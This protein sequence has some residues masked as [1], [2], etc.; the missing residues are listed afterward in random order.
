[1]RVQAL[2]AFEALVEESPD[3]SVPSISSF[4]MASSAASTE[5]TSS[6]TGGRFL[7]GASGASDWLRFGR[8]L[9]GSAAIAR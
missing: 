3:G 5:E 2:W 1:M 9:E 6:P 8:E 4:V 7:F